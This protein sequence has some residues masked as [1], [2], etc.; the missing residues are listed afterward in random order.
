V[1]ADAPPVEVLRHTDDATALRL[2]ATVGAAWDGVAPSDDD[3]VQQAAD[4]AA[5]LHRNGLRLPDAADGFELGCGAGR[6]TRHL[7]GMVSRLAASDASAVQL[8]AAQRGGIANLALRPAD[9]LRF[10][11]T[12]AFD[13]WCSFHALQHSPPPLIARALARAFAQLR[14]G[15]VAIF[16]L[17]TYAYGYGYTAADLARPPAATPYDDRHVLPQS[18]VFAIAAE[19]GCEPVELVEDLSVGPNALWRSTLFVLR[20]RDG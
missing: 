2:L 10:G 5:C 1:R 3:G 9:D 4:V 8:A 17:P 7:A 20:K 12:E 16:Q 15:G 19:H 11:M 14:P 13:L 6:V 18:A